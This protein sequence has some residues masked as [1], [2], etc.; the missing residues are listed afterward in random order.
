M[1]RLVLALL[2]GLTALP[3]VA[4][5]S[6]PIPAP[7]A[8]P[9]PSL[10]ADAFDHYT[11]GRTLSYNFEGTPYGIEEYLP[12][13][14]VQWAFMGQECQ[15]GIWYERNGNICFIYDNAPSDEQCWRF[16]GT[17]TG[18][19]GVFQGVDGPGTELYEVQQSDAPL[20]CMGPGVGV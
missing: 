2:V 19:R 5:V 17:E 6:T 18:L 4:Q 10:N 15:T 9:G 11:L 20:T 3:A 7:E 12:N 13:R 16:Y 8:I 1:R 14:R